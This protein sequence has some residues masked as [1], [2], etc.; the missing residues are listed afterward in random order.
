MCECTKT[1]Y[2]SA[3]LQFLRD[4]GMTPKEIAFLTRTIAVDALILEIF[5]GNEPPP[6]DPDTGLPYHWI[7]GNQDG[8][9]P[10]VN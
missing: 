1:L 10:E 3:V 8:A 7:L 6:F 4:E 5:E 2:G 9:T